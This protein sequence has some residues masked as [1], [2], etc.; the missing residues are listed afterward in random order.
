MN[1]T[2]SDNRDS[3]VVIRQTLRQ[4]EADAARLRATLTSNSG[5]IG[6]GTF[7]VFRSGSL[8]FAI[9]VTVI[10][11]VVPACSLVQSTGVGTGILGAIQMA[12]GH[13]PIIDIA[14]WC[15]AGQTRITTSH[16]YVLLDSAPRTGVLV[17]SFGEIVVFTQNQKFE[18]GHPDCPE[19]M[20]VSTVS[21][22]SGHPVYLLAPDVLAAQSVLNSEPEEPG[23]RDTQPRE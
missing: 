21:D 22:S 10:A 9:D 2:I 7:Q 1:T 19:I 11:R 13:V 20:P 6:A 15:G 23:G 3:A 5:E 4:L 14:Q 16:S 18:S 17:D 12:D 8:A